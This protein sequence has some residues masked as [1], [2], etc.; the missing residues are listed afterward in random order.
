[1]YQRLALDVPAAGTRCTSAW[2]IFRHTENKIPS[3]WESCSQPLGIEFPALGNHVP[4]PWESC[5]QPLGIMFP[6]LGNHVPSRWESCSQAAWEF[7]WMAEHWLKRRGGGP[8][9]DGAS[10]ATRGRANGRRGRVMKGG[11]EALLEAIC[12]FSWQIIGH[13]SKNRYLCGQQT[14]QQTTM[15]ILRTLRLRSLILCPQQHGSEPCT[16][17]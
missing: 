11:L 12:H 10:R 5:S 6:A 14:P 17:A 9:R 7:L 2:R 4:S 15:N 1:M 13:L 8:A 3:R 16:R